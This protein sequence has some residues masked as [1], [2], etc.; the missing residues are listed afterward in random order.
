MADTGSASTS[1]THSGLTAGSTRHY[2]V[3]AI[4]SA[5]TG[6][7]SGSA[8]ATTDS[9]QVQETTCSLEL[10]VGAGESCTYPRRTEEFSVDSSGTG[11][12]LFFSS[13]LK[14]EIRDTIVNGV[15]YTLVASNQGDGTWLIEEVG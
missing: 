11:S 8:S 10:V 15:E 14:I 12:F 1:Y 13:A 5:G 2:R 4:N 3:S 9:V 7:A 6:S